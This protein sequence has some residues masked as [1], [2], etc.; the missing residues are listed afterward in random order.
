M[1]LDEVVV[2][3]QDSILRVLCPGMEIGAVDGMGV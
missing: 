1:E 2:G 3:V